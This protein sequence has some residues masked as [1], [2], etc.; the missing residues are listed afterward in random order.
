MNTLK[1]YAD[2][3]ALET[4]KMHLA[5]RYERKHQ[6]LKKKFA[7]MFTIAIGLLVLA[8]AITGYTVLSKSAQP[9]NVSE[10]YKVQPPAIA[11]QAPSTPK[12]PAVQESAS[13]KVAPSA[14][15]VQRACYPATAVSAQLDTLPAF[16]LGTSEQIDFTYD[17]NV[18]LS[19]PVQ[20]WVSSICKSYGIDPY[21]VYAV[22]EKESQYGTATLS[23]DGQDYGIM[24]IRK[25][26]HAWLNEAI[27]RELDFNDVY[28]NSLA[29]IYMLNQLINKHGSKGVDYVLMCYNMG[30][31]GAASSGKT[32]TAY[33]QHI[34]ETYHQLKGD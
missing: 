16:L 12:T 8:N 11:A 14:E 22:M 30:E 5:A 4:Y 20:S 32:S 15:A 21:L 19:L 9:E 26:N 28:D 31:G 6:R 34:M 13:P 25:L 24:Q 3:D 7:T 23:A 1:N 33:S 2:N 17:A 27:G 10:E 18:P 29:G